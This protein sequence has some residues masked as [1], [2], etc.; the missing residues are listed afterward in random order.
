M[1]GAGVNSDS[2]FTSSHYLFLE[3]KQQQN[4]KNNN[5]KTKTKNNNKKTTCGIEVMFG[6]D[7]NVIAWLLVGMK[8]REDFWNNCIK[9][10]DMIISD[11]WRKCGIYFSTE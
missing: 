6:L 3:E 4:N 11:C 1:H 2:K 10:H 7:R 5:N 8:V 9:S